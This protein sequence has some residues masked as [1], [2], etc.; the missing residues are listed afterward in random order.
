MTVE[1]VSALPLFV[2]DSLDEGLFQ[3]SHGDT[4]AKVC[5]IRRVGV[6]VDW[7]P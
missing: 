3:L 1:G 2:T 6:R 5:H 7:P 4:V